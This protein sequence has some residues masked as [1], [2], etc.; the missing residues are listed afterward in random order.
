MRGIVKG[1]INNLGYEVRRIDWTYD[2]SEEEIRAR[3]P[4]VCIMQSLFLRS[5]A[6]I[7][8]ILWR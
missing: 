1:I 7:W 5:N 4:V 8:R 2:G 3:Y 6:E